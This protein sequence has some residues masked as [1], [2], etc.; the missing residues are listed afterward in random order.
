MEDYKKE[1]GGKEK[2]KE[3]N[4]K[5]INDDYVK[6]IRYGQHFI[7]KNGE[8]ILAFI[9]AHGFLDNPTFRGMRWNLLK[10]YDKIIT[11]DLLGNSKK[12]EKCP[13]GSKDENV[14]D[15]QQGVSI[16]LFVKTGKK[17]D[18]ELGQISHLDIHG[19][20]KDKYGFLLANSID[21][22]PYRNLAY[23]EPDYFFVPKD[24]ESVRE[25]KKGIAIDEFFRVGNSGV[26]TKRDKL[27]IHSTKQEVIQM[28]NDVMQLEEQQCRVKYSIP[29]D[30][31]DWN[32]TLAKSD[33][34]KSGLNLDLVRKINYRPFDSKYFYYTGRSK[35]IVGWPV[36]VVSE[37]LQRVDNIGFMTNKKVEVG[38][39]AHIFFYRGIVESHAVSMKEINYVFPLYL[40]PDDD[41]QSLEGKPTRTPNLNPDI[42][43]QIAAKLGL[44]FTPEKEKAA[45]TF[46]PI[47][48][49]DYIYAVLHS[50]T[51][52]E[53]YK[54]FLKIDFPRVPYPH[55]QKI[56]RQLV[57]L[58]G[59]LRQIHLL[60]HSVVDKRITTFPVD[61]DNEIIRRLGKQDWELTDQKRQLGRIH[62]N[63][64][65]Y[66]GDIPLVAWEFYIGGYQPAQKWLKD[67]R[68]RQLTFEDVS[69]YQ[70]IIVALT[71]T[72]RLMREIDGIEIEEK[73]STEDRKAD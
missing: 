60:E 54:E 31:R 72:D 24:L 48:L 43:Q 66:F 20:R 18:G 58:G 40:Y 45:G 52:R 37:H 6:F 10:T 39:F 29:K 67:R 13:D 19:L 4:S 57:E 42:V 17:R 53:K 5:W 16:N 62:I 49:L 15:I 33:I 46:A 69:H 7:E 21:S 25:Y 28:L 11:I 70:K 64:T 35:G 50:P 27:N 61:G 8:G 55:D 63:D 56:F 41:Q 59:K 1:P 44:T 36:P 3:R 2:L 34:T 51:Y 30:V 68:K 71:E 14:F 12:K 32:F 65:Q 23:V 9:N 22:S 73:S 26:V 38:E 47:D